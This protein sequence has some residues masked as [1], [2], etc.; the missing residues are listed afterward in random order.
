MHGIKKYKTVTV[1]AIQNFHK[2]SILQ[3][4]LKY[5]FFYLQNYSL[6]T[7]ATGIDK[8]LVLNNVEA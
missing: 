4:R 6:Y 2:R 7:Y 8:R 3:V 1:H 5:I